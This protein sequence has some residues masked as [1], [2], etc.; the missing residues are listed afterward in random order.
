MTDRA[1]KLHHLADR[2]EAGEYTSVDRFTD[3]ISEVLA[4][5]M[6]A[7]T[8]IGVGEVGGLIYEA[9]QGSVEAALRLFPDRNEYIRMDYHPT[10]KHY[11]LYWYNG[12]GMWITAKAQDLA[13]AWL[14][15]A[16]RVWAEM[17]EEG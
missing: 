2:V 13:H 11:E 16:L 14:A 7:R 10:Y 4:P 12:S 6:A 8:T 15:L 17:E 1:D 5:V 3:E 9:L